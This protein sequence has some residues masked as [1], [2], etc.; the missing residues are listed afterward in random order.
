MPD[1]ERVINGLEHCRRGPIGCQQKCPYTSDFGCRSQ[2][3][4]DALELL[5]ARVL[6]PEELKAYD[7]YAWCEK[8]V[9][10][11]MYVSLIKDGLLYDIG[12]PAY[13][14]EKLNWPY[15]GKGWRYWS[16]QPTE[17]QREAVK[18]DE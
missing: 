13:A 9:K 1:R 10:K 12:K 18:W 2:L 8:K 4:A 7:G 14:V 6:T 3:A 17:E 5:K 11:I 16:A 15:Y